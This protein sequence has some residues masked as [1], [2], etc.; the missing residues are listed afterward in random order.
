M[1]TDLN[2]SWINNSNTQIYVLPQ[3]N[4]QSENDFN[5]SKLNLSWITHSYYNDTMEINI[6]FDYPMEISPNI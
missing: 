2:I 1:N 5:N 6:I 3:D 4:R